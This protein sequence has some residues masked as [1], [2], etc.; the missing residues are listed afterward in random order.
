LDGAIV[1]VKMLETALW[2]QSDCHDLTIDWKRILSEMPLSETERVK[3]PG[4]VAH[5]L[6]LVNLSEVNRSELL[7]GL[8][9]MGQ[10]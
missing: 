4:A 6:E 2:D 5:M 7:L 9:D 10:D 1:G 3:R 8:S